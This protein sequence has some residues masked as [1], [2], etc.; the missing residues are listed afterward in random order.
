MLFF[1]TTGYLPV[2]ERS[3]IVYYVM[4]FK[5]MNKHKQLFI[6]KQDKCKKT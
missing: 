1:A 4:E 6:H 3:H 5:T 2:H